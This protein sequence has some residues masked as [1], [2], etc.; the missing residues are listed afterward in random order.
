MR[1][2]SASLLLLAA[3]VQ[4]APSAGPDAHLTPDVGGSD[5][6][7]TDAGALPTQT[8]NILLVIADDLGADV[9]PCMAAAEHR[10]P[11]PHVEALCARGVV[12]EHAWSNPTCSPTRATILT[13]RYS[14]R[15]GVGQQMQGNSTPALPQG[16]VA[17]PQ[18]LAPPYASAA[19]GKWHL[20]NTS[21]GGAAHPESTGF[22]HYAGLMIGAHRDY[23]NWERTEDRQQTS[24][25]DYSTTRMT[26]DAITW[27]DAQPTDQPWFLWLAYTAPH[28][29]MHLPPEGLHSQTGLTGQRQ[30]VRQNGKLYYRAVAE[31][32][33]TELGRLLDH[34][35]PETLANTWVIFVGDNGTAGQL[36]PAPRTRDNAKGTL[37][38]GGIHVPLVIAGPGLEQP[39]RRINAPV[40]LA[41][42]H[43]T[44]GE[45]SG[46]PRGNIEGINR[47]VDSVSL[48]PYLKEVDAQAQRAWVY[49]EIFGPTIDEAR[50]G[51]TLRNARY[52]IIRFD[53]GGTAFFDLE[54]DPGE[55]TNLTPDNRTPEQNAAFDELN[56]ALVDLTGRP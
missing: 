36:V 43:S 54:A 14:F 12:F 3:C 37:Y 23:Y 39:G 53:Q 48:V 18:V 40:N 15:T 32:L 16:E 42:L 29:P 20:A 35:G 46:T 56:H 26:N 11:M 41:D 44:I 27:L 24:V 22:D 19:I 55:T 5:A 25:T 47:V 45:L 7:Q 21:N 28:T 49:S 51:R 17:L 33:D 4:N 6:G 30:H 38:E 10:V 50:A 34:L 31:A 9:A 1:I 13:G 2:L 52:K 8:P